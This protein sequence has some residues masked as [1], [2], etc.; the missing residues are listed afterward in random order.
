M[1]VHEFDFVIVGGG[2]VGLAVGMKLTERFPRCKIALLEKE[3][4]PAF[5]QSGRN[6]GVIHSG[7]Y[8]KPGSL[9][10]RFAKEGNGSMLAFCQANDIPYEVCGKLIVAVDSHDLSRLKLLYDRGRDNGLPVSWLESDVAK[11]IEPNIGC[12]AAIRVA[13]TGI[14]NYA[15]VSQRYLRI[16]TQQGGEFFP[17]TKAQAIR[18]QTQG[19]LVAT[20]N[21]DFLA[22]FFVNCAGLFSDRLAK[23]SGQ[24]LTAKILPFR[25]EYYDLVPEKTGLINNL[26]YPVPNPNLPFLGVHLT[27]TV[28]G[29]IHVGPNAV[30]A[31]KREGYSKFDVNL[32]DALDSLS[33][34]GFWRLAFRYPGEG[35]EEMLRSWQKSLFVKT[36]RTFVP[37]IKASDLQPSVAG[38]R[39][40]ALSLSGELIDDFWF[41]EAE[42]AIHIGNA[43]SPAA[44][45]SL[46]IANFIVAKIADRYPSH[47]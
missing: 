4:G 18:F 33:Y 5:H 31:L 45:A 21:G 23:M 46:E 28:D 35:I 7:I 32:F 34:P 30:L 36:I 29:R 25:G 41:I 15:D 2:I 38:V 13:S 40:Q 20:N 8:Y 17:N 9:K 3:S 12:L 26:I 39:A 19:Y 42:Q 14:V 44:T 43:P 22:K 47:R 37:S 27:R 1:P 24:K 11:E 6:S 16:M 10:A